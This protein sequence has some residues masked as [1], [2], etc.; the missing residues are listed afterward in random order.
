MS[1]RTCGGWL[2]PALVFCTPLASVGEDDVRPACNTKTQGTMWPEAANR[3][4]SLIARL[5]RCGELLICVRGTWHYHWEPASVT[6]EQLRRKANAQPMKPSVCEV[7]PVADPA[8]DT[9]N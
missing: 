3:D 4:R 9:G 2:L 8:T 1:F 6:I 7:K 5:V